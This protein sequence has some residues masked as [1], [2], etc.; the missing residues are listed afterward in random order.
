MK[1]LEIDGKKIPCNVVIRDVKYAYLRLKPN[2]CLEIILPSGS[3]LDTD[4]LLRKKQKW[5]EEKVKEFTNTVKILND[6][7]ILY[8]GSLLNVKVYSAK[9]PCRGVRLYNKVIF[10]YEDSQRESH[11]ILR[12][13]MSSQTLDYVKRRV[14]K[15]ADDCHN[16]VRIL[17]WF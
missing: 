1:I 11:E 6:D 4:A 3:N 2:L 14:R 9:R 12:D 16:V 17:R 13:F 15:F 8:K 7:R 10:V 5:I